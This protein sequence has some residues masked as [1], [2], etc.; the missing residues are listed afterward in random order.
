MPQPEFNPAGTN[1]KECLTGEAPIKAVIDVGTNSVKLLL[2]TV[3]GRAVEPVH[4]ESKQTRLGAGFYQTRILC[5]EPIRATAEAVA[6]FAAKAREMRAASIRVIGTSA[7]RDALNAAELIE[8]I[9]AASGLVLE[10]ISGDVEADWVYRGVTSD[11]RLAGRSMMILDIGGGSSEFIVGENFSKTFSGSFPLGA[12][13]TIESLQLADPPGLEAMTRC[14][15]NVGQ[16]LREHVLA[17]ASTALRACSTRPI[18]IGTGG[19]ATI[20]AC[21]AA[22]AKEFNR[23][24]IES[25]V[26]TAEQ[27]R[28]TGED[29]WQQTLAQRQRIPGLPPKR[30][31]VILAGSVIYATIMEEMGF[32]ELRI[33]T[34]GL[35]YTALAG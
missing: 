10:I 30:A 22:R 2:A 9:R 21:M 6:F 19:T 26:I 8:A 24:Q 35:R 31:D 13:R 23:E 27:V 25:L 34:R 12:V 4:E 5:A 3:Q 29:L 33:S 15:A 7:A 17:E 1:P 18:L 28:H 20:L 32:A 14:R 11:P 16:F